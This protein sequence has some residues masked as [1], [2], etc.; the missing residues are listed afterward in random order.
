MGKHHSKLKK[1]EIL[2]SMGSARLEVNSFRDQK[3]QKLKDHEKELVEM[4]SALEQGFQEYRMKATV[5]V[6]YVKYVQATKIMLEMIS[7][8]TEILSPEKPKREEFEGEFLPNLRSVMWG[9]EK[10]K[11]DLREFQELMVTAFGKRIV[12]YGDEGEDVDKE[13]SFE[14]FL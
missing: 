9:L 4:I 6:R 7:R 11:V 8:M 13:V 5:C 10:I 3:I 12:M 1:E 2:G 14:E